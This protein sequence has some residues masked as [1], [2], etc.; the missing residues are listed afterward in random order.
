M[1]SSCSLTVINSPGIAL[2]PL[3]EI[4]VHSL[5]VREHRR[6]LLRNLLPNEASFQALRRHAHELAQKARTPT[7]G[8]TIALAMSR[9]IVP[10]YSPQSS[11]QSVHP[12]QMCSM[13]SL[14]FLATAQHSSRK[15]CR[16]SCACR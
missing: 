13:L 1:A 16:S 15:R 12:S 10:T 2:P 7:D 5:Q 4:A 6:L 9:R 8:R 14:S 3:L 11:A